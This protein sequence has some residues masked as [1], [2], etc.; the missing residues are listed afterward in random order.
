VVANGIS[1]RETWFHSLARFRSQNRR[2][3]AAFPLS[4][5]PGNKPPKT[6]AAASGIAPESSSARKTTTWGLSYVITHFSAQP[7]RCVS[8]RP[9]IQ[10][11]H[12]NFTSHAQKRQLLSCKFF[13]RRVLSCCL[14][15]TRARRPTHDYTQAGPKSF[16]PPAKPVKLRVSPALSRCRPRPRVSP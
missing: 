7:D 5:S 3:R 12:I 10:R 8:R 13:C 9:E 11:C 2:L 4:R 14:L 16:I 6:L 1:T 15:L